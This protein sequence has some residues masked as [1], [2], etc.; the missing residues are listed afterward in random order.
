MKRT[1]VSAIA[2]L[3]LVACSDDTNDDGQ[4]PDPEVT[5]QA[6]TDYPLPGEDSYPYG[7]TGDPATGRFYVSSGNTAKIFSGTLGGELTLWADFTTANVRGGTGL[8]LTA[9]GKTLVWGAQSGIHVIDVA[10]RTITRTASLPG[11]APQSVAVSP[12]GSK[13]YFVDGQVNAIYVV[14]LASG[15]VTTLVMPSSTPN[16]DPEELAAGDLFPC[17]SS[18]EQGFINASGVAATPD[19]RYVIVVH[20]IDKHL[21]RFDLSALTVKRVDTGAYYLSGNGLSIAAGKLYE[22]LADESR[23]AEYTLSADYAAATF[24]RKLGDADS[25]ATPNEAFRMGDVLLVAS[26]Q[27]SLTAPGG[28]QGGGAQPGGG[29]PASCDPGAGQGGLTLPPEATTACEGA[30]AGAACGFTALGFALTG[31]CT[32]AE[33]GLQCVPQLGGGLGGT[34]SFTTPTKVTGIAL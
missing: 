5:P 12:D 29:A 26:T 23:I 20:L 2:L 27:L 28:N 19:G 17:I 25:L 4:V 24:E 31:T 9:D 16:A 6:V 32:P 33:A 13:A 11:G 18:A 8:Q 10:T 14:E 3:C 30:T 7:V 22:A 34:A 21:Y 15:A 1:Y